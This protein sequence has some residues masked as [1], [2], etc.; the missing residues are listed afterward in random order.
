MP[1]MF[2]VLSVLVT[3]TE[4]RLDQIANVMP[5]GRESY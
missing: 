1:V 2:A 4:K 5:V 3:T